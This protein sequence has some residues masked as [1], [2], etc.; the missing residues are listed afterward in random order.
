L[1]V[2]VYGKRGKHPAEM[3]LSED[4][5]PVGEIGSEGQDEAFGD[6]S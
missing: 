5:H 4:Q 6:S 3:L 1:R 2:V